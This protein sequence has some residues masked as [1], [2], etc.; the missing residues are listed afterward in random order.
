MDFFYRRDRTLVH[1][2]GATE[3]ATDRAVQSTWQALGG[4]S[5]ADHRVVTSSR[6]G[7]RSSAGLFQQSSSRKV[8]DGL[9]EADSG[10]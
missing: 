1:R 2:V 6:G 5:R 10:H 9:Q 7:A 3:D 8:P 4:R